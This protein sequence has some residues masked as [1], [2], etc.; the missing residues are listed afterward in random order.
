M[1]RSTVSL[2][3]DSDYI[4]SDVTREFDTP[5]VVTRETIHSD[6][7]LTFIAEV[8]A[9]VDGIV[10]RLEQS[11]AVLQVGK[12]SDSTVLIRKQ[13][14]GAIPIIREYNGMLYGINSAYGT[15][16]VF[17]IL[18]FDREDV[19]RIVEEFDEFGT[20]RLER[21][22]PVPDRPANLSERQ[23]EVVTTAIEEGYYDWPRKAEAKEIAE[24]L[25]ITHPTFLEHLRKAEQKLIRSSLP[26]PNEDLFDEFEPGSDDSAQRGPMFEN[27][28]AM[29][30]PR[31]HS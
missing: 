7:T 13:S 15:T 14:C 24:R 4:L 11:E 23:Y 18:T 22:A 9:S 26:R 20:A 10:D 28:A 16:R 17:E 21:I 5:L 3:F 19:R 25:G 2:D 27:L 1:L 30:D 31:L 6:N 12:I 8:S 29:I